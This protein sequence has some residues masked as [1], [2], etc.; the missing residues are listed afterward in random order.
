MSNSDHTITRRLA[1][2]AGLGT[3]AAGL[4][5]AARAQSQGGAYPNRPVTMIVGFP[6]GGQTDFAARIVQPGLAQNLGQSVVIDN[7]GGAGGNIG[8]EA[9]LRARPDGY[10]LLAGNSSP[11]AI[12]PHTF[13]NMTINP[14]DLMPIG[15]TLQSSMVL[16]VHPSVPANNVRELAAWIKA[17]P[18]GVNYGSP[19]AGSLSHCAMELF[20]D[21]IGKPEMESVPYRGS[22]PAIQDFV[23]NRFSAMF[24]AA[25]VLSPFIKS[26]Q[27]KPILVSGAARAPALPDVPTAAEQ[28]LPDFVF[29]AWIGLFAP[30]GTPDEVIQRVHAAQDAALKDQAVRDKITGQ[31][32]EPGGGSIEDFANMVRRDHARWGKVVKENNITAV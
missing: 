31:G 5:P 26:G 4:A 23:A 11:M 30:K 24:D 1:L 16:C 15:L 10:T 17:Q 27:L 21:R 32:D 18:G 9:V 2:G 6:P 7:R 22:G 14:L 25:S 28:G 19:T 13:P 8:T 20:R 29:T 3:V 12:N